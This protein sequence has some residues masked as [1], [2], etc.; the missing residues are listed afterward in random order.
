MYY[1]YLIRLLLSPPLVSFLR[2][3]PFVR[4]SS[5]SFTAAPRHPYAHVRRIGPPTIHDSPKPII[6]PKESS[7]VHGN[8]NWPSETPNAITRLHTIR[9]YR[10]HICVRLLGIRVHTYYTHVI[11]FSHD[12]RSYTYIYESIMYIRE[13]AYT[14]LHEGSPSRRPVTRRN[15][16]HG[17]NDSRTATRPWRAGRRSEARFDVDEEALRFGAGAGAGAGLDG[18]TGGRWKSASRTRNR[19]SV[20]VRPRTNQTKRNETK[21]PV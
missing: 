21:L 11:M 4:L 14:K 1:R 3:V 18:A 12:R 9:N 5:T 6:R 13:S 10:T 19:G 16:W 20:S 2:P 15:I 8:Q 17:Q 7:R